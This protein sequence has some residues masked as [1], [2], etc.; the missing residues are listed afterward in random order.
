MGIKFIKSIEENLNI[1]LM[2]KYARTVKFLVAMNKGIS[3]VG[4]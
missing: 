3:I 1:L 2:N 4:T